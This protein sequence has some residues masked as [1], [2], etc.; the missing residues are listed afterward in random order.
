VHCETETKY[1]NTKRTIQNK[2]T[3]EH[4]REQN[5]ES[6]IIKT[7]DTIHVSVFFLLR[8]NL[9]YQYYLI[10]SWK[11]C[12]WAGFINNSLYTDLCRLVRIQHYFTAYRRY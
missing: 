5:S 3:R 2:R 11:S 7:V 6:G 9:T 12:F 10:P 8:A 4:Y 1:R